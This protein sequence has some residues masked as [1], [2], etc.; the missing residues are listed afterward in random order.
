MP[1]MAVA[2]RLTEL[3]DGI[4]ELIQALKTSD[5]DGILMASKKVQELSVTFSNL[6][7]PQ[8]GPVEEE[9]VEANWLQTEMGKVRAQLAQAALFIQTVGRLNEALL[10]VLLANPDGQSTYTAAGLMKTV[11]QRGTLA[12]V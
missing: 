10:G 4:D 6:S 9:Q 12:R 11:G 8:P 7:I 5:P 2:R 1:S 3:K